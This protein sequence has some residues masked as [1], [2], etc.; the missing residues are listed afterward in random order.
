MVV[1]SL[2]NFARFGGLVVG[3]ANTTS[4]DYA[5]VIGVANTASG[6]VSTVSGGRFRTAE[7]GFDWVAGGLFQDE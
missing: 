3:T 1:G 6:F 2:H 4:G 7:G 5:T